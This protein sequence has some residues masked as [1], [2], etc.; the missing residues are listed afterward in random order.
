MW[1][2]KKLILLP[3]IGI[4]LLLSFFSPLALWETLD[5]STFHFLNSFIQESTLAQNF[6]AF[7]GNRAMDWIHDIVMLTFFAVAIKAAPREL[8]LRKVGELLFAALIIALV[9]TQVTKF[10]HVYRHSPSLVEEGAFRLSEVIDWIKVKDYSKKSFPGDHAITAT[11]FSGFIFAFMGLRAGFL[12]FLYAIFWCLPRL[13]LGAHHLSDLLVGSL[14]ISLIT[15]GIALG[16]PIYFYFQKILATL[17]MRPW[18]TI[19]SS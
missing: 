15:L 1:N 16:T 9:I 6:W 19:K 7:T 2:L 12:S 3:S 17:I 10:V 14:S 8:K 5:R 4:L 11:L 18:T 13:I